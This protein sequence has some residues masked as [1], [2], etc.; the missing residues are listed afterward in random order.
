M[1][2]EKVYNLC[3]KVIKWYENSN[4]YFTDFELT[5]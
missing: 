1:R 4:T 2:I 5:E 3:D